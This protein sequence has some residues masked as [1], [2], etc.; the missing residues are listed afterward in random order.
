M[1]SNKFVVNLLVNKNPHPDS[2][3]ICKIPFGTEYGL[4]LRNR[5][6]RRALVKIFID[7]ENVSDGGFV[8]EA[9]NY[10]NLFRSSQKD[11]AFK[12]VALDSPEAYDFG[13]NGPN[14]DKIKG[15]I[16]AHFY[17]EKERPTP[18]KE[19][20]H[21][22]HHDHH[23]YPK[24]RN[25]WDWPT[26]MPLCEP[27]VTFMS[28]SS[29]EVNWTNTSNTRSMSYGGEA[30]KA[31]IEL[32]GLSGSVSSNVEAKVPEIHPTTTTE[33]KDGC[34]VEGATTGQN[35]HYVNFDAEETYTVVKLLLQ[36]YEEEKTVCIAKPAMKQPSKKP[37]KNQRIDDLEAENEE[38]RRKLAE[39]ENKKLKKKLK[40]L[41]KDTSE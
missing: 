20:H 36:G 11:A 38:L 8:I 34:T 28:N 24:R 16:E 9:N 5:H 29:N 13:K 12:F 35:F 37:H 14:L 7:G 39:I 6:N 25:P 2:N 27:S 30:S 19:I 1:Y 33:L 40:R 31:S 17:L 41:E 10:M 4:R 22:H 32:C 3:G 18:V 26:Y 21:H 15:T 23:H